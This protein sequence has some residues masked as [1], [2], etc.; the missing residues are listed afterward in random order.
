VTPDPEGEAGQHLFEVI[1][2]GDEPYPIYH[3]L[4]AHGFEDE[5]EGHRQTQLKQ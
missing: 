1:G 3:F 2:G 4:L 5:G